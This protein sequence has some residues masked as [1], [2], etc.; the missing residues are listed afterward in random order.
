MKR[1]TT[2]VLLA[3]GILA[4]FVLP[5]FAGP[6]AAIS[7]PKFALH[8]QTHAQKAS[9]VCTTSNPNTN[10]IA[11][12]DYVTNWPLLTG[13]D[14]YLVLAQGDSTGF[15]G[16]TFG[17]TY[18]GGVNSVGSGVDL[19]GD[20]TFCASGL[21][22]PSDT[23]PD[24]DSGNLVTFLLPTDCQT[25]K[26]GSDGVQA[27]LGAFYIYAYSADNFRIREHTELLS[28]PSL[29]TA[30]CAGASTVYPAEQY[31]LRCGFV[32]FGPSNPGC[33][34][35]T[36]TLGCTTPTEKTTWGQIKSMYQPGS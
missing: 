8:A 13:T 23:W 27:V 16:A 5:A 32:G 26:F 10:G 18:D 12:S 11:C 15:S 35:C 19:V 29:A 20:W 6:S 21:Q 1:Y 33:N 4:L 36:T 9:T 34:P 30:N 28:G 2:A 31:P 14:V 24:P 25:T 17:I 22:F 3:A 7:G